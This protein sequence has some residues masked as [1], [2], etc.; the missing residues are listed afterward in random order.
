VNVEAAGGGRGKGLL[1]PQ[2]TIELTL[3]S[4]ARTSTAAHTSARR[5]PTAVRS[6]S[7]L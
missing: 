4:F 2:N 6:R 1:K 7:L 5:P 3:T